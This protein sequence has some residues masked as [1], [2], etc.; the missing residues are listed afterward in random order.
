[1]KVLFAALTLPCMLFFQ[2][3]PQPERGPQDPE[4]QPQAP[5]LDIFGRTK[6]DG[7]GGTLAMMQGAWQLMGVKAS[8]Y[9][10][11]GMEPAG[12]MVISDSFMA[13]T[14]QISWD[15]DAD[16][17]LDFLEDYQS[18]IADISPLAGGEIECATLIGASMAS[19]ANELDWEARG[20][21]RRF[22]VVLQGN[23]M[24]LKWGGDNAL[25]FGRRRS[26]RPGKEGFFGVP[27]AFGGS[28][29][30]DLFGRGKGEKKEEGETGR[31][32]DDR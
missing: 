4:P 12:F 10:L 9:P 31:G 14:V 5:D 13:M 8:D 28:S 24:E 19:D 25:T 6:E 16:S 26:I 27:D 11:T 22:R 29:N 23:M 2:D 21:K 3:P 30:V 1:M 17:G 15:A 7:S 32:G 18:F 20:Q